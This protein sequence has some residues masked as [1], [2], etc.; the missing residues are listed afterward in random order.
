MSQ[1]VL[2]ILDCPDLDLAIRV[3]RSTIMNASSV[4]DKKNLE[5]CDLERWDYLN[6]M[7][8]M[9]IKKGILEVFKGTMLDKVT[10]AND[11]LEG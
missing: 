9:I 11:F 7:S 5:R 8:F 3:T 1:N 6:H 2:I 4:K 10:N